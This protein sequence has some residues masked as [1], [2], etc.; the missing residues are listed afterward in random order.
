MVWRNLVSRMKEIA[1]M[2]TQ[3]GCVGSARDK[4]QYNLLLVCRDKRV[5]RSAHLESATS[6][7]CIYRLKTGNSKKSGASKR[8]QKAKSKQT[9]TF[10]HVNDAILAVFYFR[11]HVFARGKKSVTA[12][13]HSACHQ[14]HC[15][16]PLCTKGNVALEERVLYILLNCRERNYR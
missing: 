9:W 4:P 5:E 12:L 7:V 2:L 1:N 11:V 16:V 3:F 15:S 14:L 10:K 6:S 13:H 8:K